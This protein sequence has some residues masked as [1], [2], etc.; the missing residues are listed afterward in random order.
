MIKSKNNE[1]E[2]GRREKNS[3][4]LPVMSVTVILFALIL[5]AILVN[6]E[7]FYAVLNNLIMN[8][9]MWGLG[10]FLSFVCLAMVIFCV[11]VMVTPLGK[12]KLGGPNAKPEF[13]Y[14]QWFGISLT[15]GIGAGIV[16]WGAA[17]PLLFAMEP[18]PSTG[19][20]GGSNAAVLWS[21][22]R[23][24]MEWGLT[25]YA[26]CVVMG[27]VLSYVI[28][29]KKAPFKTS[30]C[31][32]PIFGDDVVHS[33]MAHAFD[34]VTAFAL[35]GAVAGGLGYGAM[36]LSTAVESF[37]GIKPSMEI[38]VGIIAVMFVC[39]NASA[40]GG[41]KKGIAWVADRNT[42][43]FFILLAF[44]FITGP[45][46]YICNL[47]AESLGG[48]IN[49]F[50]ANSLNTAPY[51]DAA[52]WPQTWDMYWWA[53]W[54]AYAPLLGLFM[55][56]VAYGRTLREFVL[57]EWLLPA[58]FG[59]VWFTVFGGTILH[60]QLWEGVDFYSVYL[61]KG[62][63]ALTLAS[64]DVLPLAT[65][66]KIVMLVIITISLVTQC[67]SMEITLASMSMKDSDEDTEAPVWL[68]LFWGIVFGV[69]AAVFVVLGGIDGVK[70]IKSF[71]GIPLTFICLFIMLGFIRYMVKRPR[72][73]DGTYV[74]EECIANA[75]DKAETAKLKADE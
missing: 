65:F 4:R 18:S 32:I 23:C 15:T 30:S 6:A 53:D 10:W 35:T 56:R 24:F 21:M 69:I 45:T 59:I 68:K 2:L 49:N 50:F 8:N 51:P 41:L 43:L 22:V 42:Q 14:F 75:P 26:T 19:L 62:A 67:N 25:P 11:V 37:A 40:I 44:V 52:R 64:F 74:Y 47:F 70:T 27:V 20:E 58:L 60:A 3:L 63:E 71:C 12:I 61:E 48:Y 38:Y 16:F 39:Y 57:I 33:K 73:E 17:E 31:L 55:V 1:G 9:A 66:M 7:G 34:A 13:G 36:Q 46:A 5:I 54:M 72:N 29:N 28:L